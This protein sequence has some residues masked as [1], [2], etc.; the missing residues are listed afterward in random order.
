MAVVQIRMDFL[1]LDPELRRVDLL[2]YVV[3]LLSDDLLLVFGY[4]DLPHKI[5]LDF[6]L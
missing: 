2:L 6:L 1:F 5:L 4:V 3:Q